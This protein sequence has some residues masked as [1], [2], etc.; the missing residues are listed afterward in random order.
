MPIATIN[1][2]IEIKDKG[3]ALECRCTAKNEQI[4]FYRSTAELTVFAFL[5]TFLLFK[6]RESD[7]EYVQ[8]Y[9]YY[10]KYRIDA[11]N[12]TYYTYDLDAS[13]YP[14]QITDFDVYST[15]P[16]AAL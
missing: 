16:P 4:S 13:A 9:Q 1:R 2:K 14:R 5:L 12:C 7:E 3:L 11:E 8:G 10:H 15:T 6:F